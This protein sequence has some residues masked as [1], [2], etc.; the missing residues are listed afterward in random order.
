MS[1][2]RAVRMEMSIPIVYRRSG[3]DHWFQATVLN[4]SESGVLFGPTDLVRGAWVE[5]ILSPPR[6]VGSFPNGKQV[7]RAQIVRA[8][9]IGA[10][11]AKFEDC[12]F[13]LEL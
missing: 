7:C 5:M 11:A 2:G 1:G 8:T 6:P 9:E 4:L 12:R 10:V 13:L 3:D